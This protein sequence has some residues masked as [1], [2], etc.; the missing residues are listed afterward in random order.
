MAYFYAGKRQESQDA[1]MEATRTAQLILEHCPHA[2]ELWYHPDRVWG[3]SK[4]PL[5]ELPGVGTEIMIML[6]HVLHPRLTMMQV[7]RPFPSYIDQPFSPN[8][9]YLVLD[10]KLVPEFVH[11]PP[12]P[13]DSMSH[14]E[15]SGI[16]N[17]INWGPVQDWT[18][19]KGAFPKPP[20]AR[21]A[22]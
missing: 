16:S 3:L 1:E 7:T 12:I 9:Q 20:D 15:L 13:T 10:L 17:G 22:V 2:R 18:R 4:N 21:D 19:Q 8:L 14:L 5:Q 6:R 11:L